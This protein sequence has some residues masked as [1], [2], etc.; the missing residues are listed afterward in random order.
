M[1]YHLFVQTNFDGWIFMWGSERIAFFLFFN[2]FTLYK[3]H[4]PLF[5]FPSMTYRTCYDKIFQEALKKKKF[6]SK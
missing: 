5:F 2:S 3:V 6:L 4:D 1:L